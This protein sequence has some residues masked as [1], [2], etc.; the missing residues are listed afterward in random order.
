[1]LPK[2]WSYQTITA[3]KAPGL[4]AWTIQRG[5][6]D[7]VASPGANAATGGQFVDL[8]GN[9]TKDAGIITQEVSGVSGHTYR[10]SFQLAGNP[11]GDPPL[12]TLDVSL[13]DKKESFSFDT[14]GH[15]NADLGWA[16]HTVEGCGSS[17]FTVKFESTTK[18]IRGPNI[19]NVMLT[20][21]G[22]GCGSGI[23]LWLIIVSIVLLLALGAA[24]Y[25]YLRRK[26]SAAPAVEPAST[27]E[28]AP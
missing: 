16:T 1:V 18:G 10:L 11:N 4:G 26:R 7:V 19:D 3:G 28:A 8:N 5:S 25:F 2:G 22:S 12:K 13:G 27:A 23:P 6:V 17:K 21:L 14:K 9:D 20:D 15:T 24:A